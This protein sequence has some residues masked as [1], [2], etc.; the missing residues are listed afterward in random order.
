V[1]PRHRDQIGALANAAERSLTEHRWMEEGWPF[2]GAMPIL[3]QRVQVGEIGV[4]ERHDIAGRRRPEARLVHCHAPHRAQLDRLERRRHRRDGVGPH[5]QR[6]PRRVDLA[7]QRRQVGRFANRKH[8]RRI[9]GAIAQDQRVAVGRRVP[10]AV[11]ET[12]RVEIPDGVGRPRP[13]A[14]EQGADTMKVGD[15]RHAGEV[16]AARA[17][18]D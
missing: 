11:G 12:R 8:N 13:I 14:I 6:D 2:T 4:G 9:E 3:V 1:R 15:R 10:G 16:R 18:A 17:T 5:V 7:K